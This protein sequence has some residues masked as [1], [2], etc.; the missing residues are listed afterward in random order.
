MVLRETLGSVT[1]AAALVASVLLVIQSSSSPYSLT[2]LGIVIGGLVLAA[3][4][5]GHP[6]IF[7]SAAVLSWFAI[8][9]K[10]PFSITTREANALRRVA[11]RGD[12][13]AKELLEYYEAFG[14]YSTILMWGISLFLLAVLIFGLVRGRMS[15]HQN[16]MD[17]SNAINTFLTRV[18]LTAAV[19][20]FS[21]M[22]L[23]IMYDVL[24]RQ[25]L[26]YDPNFTRTEWYKF[27]SSTRV[28]EM[29]WHL[30]AALFLLVL[31]YA[32][33]KDAHV[34][35]ELVRDMMR[36]RMRV[37]VELL[38]SVL[39]MVPYCYVVMKYGI[40]N[41]IRSY[42]IG[43]SSAA[44]TGLPYRFIIKSMLPLGFALIAIA[45]LSVAMRC[46][47]YLF[48][49]ASLRAQSNFYAHSHQNPAPQEPAL[50]SDGSRA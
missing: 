40:E 32:Y 49:P 6:A 13:S 36:P 15:L 16:L 7:A 45:G 4:L 27:V 23:A 37:W 26:G 18:G 48:G 38:G 5:R 35:I 22:I 12:E 21:G 43:E 47:V 50:A 3:V 19:V 34:R 24:Q 1:A 41:A 33:V 11:N 28:Q 42:D 25:Y 44:L 30:H 8:E 29:E 39:F 31:G 20:L 10:Q 2:L 14:P 17:A 46:I 9:F